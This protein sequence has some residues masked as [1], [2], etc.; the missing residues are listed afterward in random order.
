V[1]LTTAKYYTPKGRSIQSEGIAPDITV[2][3]TF[4]KSKEKITPITEKDLEKKTD[5]NP[6][7]KR[8]EEI[9]VKN[10]EDED[11][12]LYMGLQILKSWEALRGKTS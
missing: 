11:F 2:E 6:V 1:R 10:L 9:T 3:N 12:Q 5:R 7:P 4:V 8:P